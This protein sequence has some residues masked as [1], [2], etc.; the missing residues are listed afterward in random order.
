MPPTLTIDVPGA[1]GG[2]ATVELDPDGH[3]PDH[4]FVH[5]P[6]G[7]REGDGVTFAARRV[8]PGLWDT[9]FR[10]V[11]G[12]TPSE[13]IALAKRVVRQIDAGLEVVYPALADLAREHA[14]DTGRTLVAAGN[15][16]DMHAWD[17]RR[18]FA[19]DERAL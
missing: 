7:E 4:V 12:L 1:R 5:V 15:V 9:P 18:G 6:G 16:I 13:S 10:D 11:R 19:D 2:L 17:E 3:G 14:R 8:E